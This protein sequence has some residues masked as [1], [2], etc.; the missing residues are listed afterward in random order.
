MWLC[1]HYVSGRPS[2]LFNTLTLTGRISFFLIFVTCVREMFLLSRTSEY[3]LSVFVL[4]PLLRILQIF[5]S[6]IGAKINWHERVF[7]A[8]P[9]FPN[10]LLAILQIKS[11][12]LLTHNSM[13]IIHDRRPSVTIFI[14]LWG[15]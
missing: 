11:L 3:F 6:I 1:R 8:S 7:Y 12:R 13:I 4:A 15:V 9:N 5:F 10:T 14:P 2:N